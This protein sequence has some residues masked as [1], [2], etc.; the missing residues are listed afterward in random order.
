[1]N[2]N[3]HQSRTCS[4]ITAITAAALM[5]VWGGFPQSAMAQSPKGTLKVIAAV[6]NDGKAGDEKHALE[7]R[8]EDGKISVMRD[9][10]EIPA[11]QIRQEDGRIVILDKD[12]KQLQ[13][14]ALK[15]DGKPGLFGYRFGDGQWKKAAEDL[16]AQQPKVMLG[17]MMVGP[18]AALEHQLKLDPGKTAMISG[19]YEGLPAQSAG[20]A[21]YD[22]IT[23]VDGKTPA[24]NMAVKQ[25]LAKKNPGDTIELTVIH[26]GRAKDVTVKLAAYD[27]DAM[28][29]A[30]LIGSGPEQSFF[31]KFE[32]GTWDGLQNLTLPQMD[33]LFV[34]PNGNAEGDAK[35][36]PHLKELLRQHQEALGGGGSVSGGKR[37][38][39]EDQLDRLDKRMADLEQM[40]QKLMERQEKNR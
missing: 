10:K 9:G 25:V 18:G 17:L 20:L 36:V 6:A 8:V 23:K 4:L 16:K 3:H 2:Q 21:E 35:I 30:K 31:G 13:E 12:G 26:E 24:D 38:G 27:S 29:K 40:L 33:H 5:G 14:L 19:L 39:V 15:L 34:A 22:I 37:E 11:D 7:I 1:M 32:P 28:E